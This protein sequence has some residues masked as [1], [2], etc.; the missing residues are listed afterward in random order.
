MNI[1]AC[2]KG[3]SFS[4]FTYC[5]EHNGNHSRQVSAAFTDVGTRP[6]VKEEVGEK[7]A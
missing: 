7:L 5:V 1:P 3:T 6:F 2:W 4:Y